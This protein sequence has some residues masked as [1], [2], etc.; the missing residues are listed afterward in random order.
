[1]IDPGVADDDGAIPI[2]PAFGDLMACVFGLFVL[3]FVWS[4]AFQADL[5]EE[6][7]EVREAQVEDSE[8]LV[9]LEEVLATQLAEGSV[10]ITDGKIGIVGAVLFELNSADLRPEGEALVASLA[11]PLRAFAEARDVSIMIAGF[12]DTSPVIAVPHGVRDN[13]ELS[14][15][16]ALTVVRAL[17]KAG[18]PEERL[19]AAGFGDSHP[20]APNDTPENRAKNRRVEIAPLPK[21]PLGPVAVSGAT[22]TP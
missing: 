16:R 13:W 6:L 18:L 15:Q 10:T 19:F 1:M 2:W 21:G 17:E 9:E 12:T 7:A 22:G 20:V 8:R 11:G 5:S 3:F 14:S 4:V